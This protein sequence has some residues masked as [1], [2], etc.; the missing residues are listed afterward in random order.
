MNIDKF[1]TIQKMNQNSASKLSAT[2]NVIKNKFRK[3]RTNRLENEHDSVR[4]MKPLAKTVDLE[5]KNRDYSHHMPSKT[6][7]VSPLSHSTSRRCLN[8]I[9][10]SWAL[11]IKTNKEKHHDPN[12]LCDS[13]RVLLASSLN[14]DACKK[15][16]Q[17]INAIFDELRKLEI[18]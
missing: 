2:R 7:N 17:Q 4:A 11:P 16:M 10:N 12:T 5:S 1:I 18:I 15:C 14:I 6:T 8:H 13:L 9:N 3:A